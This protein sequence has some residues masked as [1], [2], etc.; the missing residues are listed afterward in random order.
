MQPTK[1]TDAD[2]VRRRSIVLIM[3]FLTCATG[4][5]AVALGHVAKMS[6]ALAG[7]LE[8]HLIFWI[9]VFLAGARV[10]TR[11]NRHGSQNLSAREEEQLSSRNSV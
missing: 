8:L 9:V 11:I 4:Y 7:D 3:L 5:F 6:D 10:L 1:L 2:L